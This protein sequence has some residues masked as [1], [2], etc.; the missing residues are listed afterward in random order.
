MSRSLILFSFFLYICNVANAQVKLNLHITTSDTKPVTKVEISVTESDSTVL[1][2]IAEMAN[3]TI[4]L[5]CQGN[6]T[7]ELGSA[8]Y[9]QLV[10]NDTF[11]A[12]TTLNLT[13]QKSAIKLE[14]VV[15]EGKSVPK[16][17]ATGLIYTLSKKAKASGNPYVALSEIPLLQ[18]DVSNQSVKMR[19]G[20]GPLILIDGRLMNSGITPISPADIESVEVSEVVSARYLQMGYSSMIN[21]K[22]RKN[23]PLYVY[24]EWRTR[25]DIP[26]R[27][28]FG[29]VNFETGRKKFSIYGSTFAN[30]T[31]NDKTDYN[32]EEKNGNAVKH[33]NGRKEDKNHEGYISLLA[34]WV[35]STYDY[36]AVNLYAGRNSG[37][38]SN[39]AEGTYT[40]DSEQ[41]MFSVSGNRSKTHAYLSRAY[42]EHRFKDGSTF[43]V[44]G[45]YA[46][47]P[48]DNRQSYEEQ[49]A[50]I[51]TN[52]DI[53]IKTDA[54]QYTLT[55]DYDHDGEK[56]GDLDIG[57]SLEYTRIQDT[58]YQSQPNL[59]SKVFMLENYSYLSYS[60]AWKRLYY[61]GSLGLEHFNVRTGDRRN[62]Y[63]KPRASISLNYNFDSV[64]RLR[65]SYNHNNFLPSASQ[66]GTLN[67]STN[68]WVVFEGNPYLKPTKRD[69][70]NFS[71]SYMGKSW[72]FFLDGS[73]GLT[74]DM[75]EQYMR[76]DGDLQIQSYRNNGNYRNTTLSFTPRYNGKNVVASVTASCFWE[77]YN[78]QNV[79]GSF[80]VDYFFKWDFGNFFLYS[81]MSWRRRSYS[82][83]GYTEYKNPTEAHVQ[84]AWQVNKKLYISLGLPYYWGIRKTVS[85][86]ETGSYFN[87]RQVSFKSSSL[88][89]WLLV[90]WTLRKHSEESIR[91][92]IPD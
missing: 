69:R 82:P 44:L 48:S 23:R 28:G 33:L 84:L 36:F 24:E 14:E 34:Q 86:T 47:Q 37:R 20:D 70:V 78:G 38:S 63:W 60:N 19:N 40:A 45:R 7:I 8:G 3:K 46:H 5:P 80:G 87:R 68:P 1:F 71:Y 31:L 73:H 62:A 56:S 65:L 64:N 79:K 76:Q 67:N 77:K 4:Y 25:H 11:S 18:V 43:S 41:Q 13:L 29:G 90:T 27:D 10:L 72:M 54:D 89:P 22:L 21:I 83:L 61:L 35:P 74:Q 52:T 6:Y 50:D 53:G 59:S 81:T 91:K 39:M 51:K 9:D 88:R 32:S 57:S 16:T 66:L 58:D 30:Y 49:Y 12:D 55:L 92:K 75:I 2:E 85:I 15:V 42:Y 17:T 26:L